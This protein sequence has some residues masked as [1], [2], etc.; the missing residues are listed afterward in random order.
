MPNKARAEAELIREIRDT[1]E[2]I[3]THNLAPYRKEAYKEKVKKLK[4]LLAKHRAA[5]KKN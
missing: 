3:D 2:I 4:E 5:N 1:Q